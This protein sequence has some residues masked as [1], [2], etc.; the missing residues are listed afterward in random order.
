MKRHSN[1]LGMIC[2]LAFSTVLVAC[3]GAKKDESTTPGGDTAALPNP[4]EGFHSVT[5]NL[6]VTDVDAA[7]DY[8][9]KAFGATKLFGLP[10][11]DGQT[12]MHAEIRIGDSVVMLGAEMPDM[13]AKSPKTLG[14]TTGSLVYYVPDADAVIKAAADAGGTV[15]MPAQDMFWGDRWGTVNDPFGHQWDIATHKEEL[16]DEQIGQRMQA[17]MS[18][19]QGGQQTPGTP[20]KSHVREGYHSLTPTLVAHDA[21]ALIAFL[22]QGLGAQEISVSPMP[23]GRIIHAELKIGDSIVTLADAF[24]EMGADAKSP[25]DLGGSP[26]ALMAYVPDTDATFQQAVGA[27]AE[28]RHQPSDAFWGDRYAEVSDPSGHL[29]GIA[30]PKEKLTPE[31]IAERM[32]SQFGGGQ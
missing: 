23:D 9:T 11:P 30:T 12:T 4:P 10:G 27:G 5:P 8:Y 17:M 13:G 15:K 26:F 19:Q 1:V 14:G 32:K 31:Q 18:G 21:K 6:V 20:A 3:G 28:A 24:P 16:T 25:K 29:W 7:V 2:L 22:K